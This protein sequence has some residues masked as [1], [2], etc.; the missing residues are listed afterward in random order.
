MVKL[1]AVLR[2]D[3]IDEIYADEVMHYENRR[4]LV[5]LWLGG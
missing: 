4:E 1:Y 5:F 2:R 3:A